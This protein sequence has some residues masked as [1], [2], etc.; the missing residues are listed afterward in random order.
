ML[1]LY[2]IYFIKLYVLSHSTTK[3]FNDYFFKSNLRLHS[4]SRFRMF[5]SILVAQ[6]GGPCVH[7]RILAAHEYSYM[8]KIK[9]RQDFLLTIN[10]IT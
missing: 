4:H 3:P 5:T 8:C 9:A 6:S 1:L 7:S 10:N 2:I